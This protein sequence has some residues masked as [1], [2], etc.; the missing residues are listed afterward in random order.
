MSNEWAIRTFSRQLAMWRQQHPTARRLIFIRG[1]RSVAQ[2]ALTVDFVL[3]LKAIGW[4]APAI[5]ALVSAQSLVGAALMMA[6]GPASDR[7]GR[8][9]PLVAYEAATVIGVAFLILTHAPWVLIAAAL[10]LSLGRGANGSAGPFAPAEQAWLANVMDDTS[11]PQMFSLNSAVG[12]WGM[13]LGSLAAGLLATAAPGRAYIAAFALAALVAA[14]NVLQIASLPDDRPDPPEAVRPKEEVADENALRRQENRSLW[15]LVG[16]NAVN[17]L[18]IS[19]TGPL[20]PYWFSLRYGVGPA[21]IG[22]VYGLTFILT[23]LGS[24]VSGELA[25]RHG[26]VATVVRI[27]AMAV[28]LLAIMPFMPTFGLAA[29]L[30]AV[31]SIAN[32]STVGV[33]QAFGVGLVRGKRRGLASSLSNLSMRIPNAIGP[34]VSGAI[35][36]AGDLWLPFGMASLFQALYVVLFHKVFA[37]R[38]RPPAGGAEEVTAGT[39]QNQ[40]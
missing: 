23:G 8:R 11:R 2:G 22:P 6:I 20:L 31:R 16:V 21:A 4:S 9:T 26:I 30:Y 28:A 12:F 3:Y 15:Q 5:G 36:A 1:L 13:G 14:S 18:G 40:D 35:F 10:V 33:R 27:R 32:R 37:G 34:T 17:A 29:A 19:L 24:L 38:D 7:L 25:R 39:W